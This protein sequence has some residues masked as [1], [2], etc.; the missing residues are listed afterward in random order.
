[1]PPT[2]PLLVCEDERPGMPAF[3]RAV[4]GTLCI[5]HEKPPS[6]LDV[7]LARAARLER[8]VRIVLCAKSIASASDTI[9]ALVRS[10]SIDLPPLDSRATELDPLILA[11][12]DDAVLEFGVETNGFREHELSWLRKIEYDSLADLAESMRRVVAI[13]NFGV[14]VAGQRLGIHYT[15]L[16]KWARRWGIPT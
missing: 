2:A 12:A 9:L 11:F 6:D 10:S 1:V 16:S 15:A 14:T 3:E 13:R 7:V 4:G 5:V 8:D